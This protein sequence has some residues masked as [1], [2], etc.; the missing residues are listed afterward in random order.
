MMTY[1]IHVIIFRKH[2]LAS[3]LLYL[4]NVFVLYTFCHNLDWGALHRPCVSLNFKGSSQILC[5]YCI[6]ITF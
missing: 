3:S 6:A 1:Y 2:F 4:W 5:L